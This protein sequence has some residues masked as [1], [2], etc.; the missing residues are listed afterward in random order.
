MRSRAPG[1]CSAEKCARDF[2]A[3]WRAFHPKPEDTGGFEGYAGCVAVIKQVR[4]VLTIQKTNRKRTINVPSA[5]CPFSQGGGPLFSARLRRLRSN[6]L[7]S[8]QISMHR[9]PS[10][11]AHAMC[12]YVG[13]VRLDVTGKT[14]AAHGLRRHGSTVSWVEEPLVAATP[15]GKI[16]D[17]VPKGCS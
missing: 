3:R 15:Q 12:V 6:S 11:R 4:T 13:I 17:I 2:S 9:M 7:P 14:R 1:H 10:G 5:Q 16:S 8:W